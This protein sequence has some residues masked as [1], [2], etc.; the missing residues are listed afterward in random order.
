MKTP[1]QSL[2]IIDNFLTPEDHSVV[3]DFFN[4]IED[5]R[6]DKRQKRRYPGSRRDYINGYAELI[7]K[8]F[9]G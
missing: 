4:V 9:F 1:R 7:E 6:I 5:A 2:E 8:D 3:K